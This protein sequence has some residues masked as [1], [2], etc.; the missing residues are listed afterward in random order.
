MD[1]DTT[2]CEPPKT[3][4]PSATASVHVVTTRLAI[5]SI[6]HRVSDEGH[7]QDISEPQLVQYKRVH[8]DPRDK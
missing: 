2:E 6:M 1:N 4:I 5:L 3:V 8:A 7:V